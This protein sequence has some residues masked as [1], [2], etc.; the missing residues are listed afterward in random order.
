MM[1]ND[2]VVPSLIQKALMIAA[3]TEA[4]TGLACLIVPSLLGQLLFGVELT[5]IAVILV[6]LAGIVLVSLAVACWRTPLIGMLTYNAAVTLYFAY[7]AF[8]GGFTG[9]LLWPVVVVH[10]ILTALLALAYTKAKS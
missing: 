9:I 1:G 5:A 2:A 8:A 3:V 4:A 6:R 7:V 10:V